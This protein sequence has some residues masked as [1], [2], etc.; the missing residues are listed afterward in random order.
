MVEACIRM[1]DPKNTRVAPVD[2]GHGRGF[3]LIELMVALA[4]S[5][6]LLIGA[7]TIYMQGRTSFRINESISR[8]QEDAR[9]ALDMLEPDI[10]M[11]SYFGLQSRPAMVE[12]RA[13]AL[14]PV[15]AGLAVNDDCRQNWAIDLDRPVEVSNNAY[16]WGGNCPAFGNG[17]A[18]GGDT[19]VVRRV[20]EDPVTVLNPNAMHLQTARFRTNVLFT[21]AAI[22]GGFP[23]GATATHDLVVNGYYVSQSSDGDLNTPSLRRYFLRAGAG[24]P[25]VEDE[26]ILPGVEDMQIQLGV[27]TDPPNSPTRGSVNRYVNGDDPIIDPLDPAFIDDAQIIAVRIWLLV[28]TDRPENG[29][30]D[31]RAYVYADRNFA[32]PNDGFRRM[33]VSRTI[34]LRNARTII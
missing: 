5:S 3:T 13:D 11:A 27:D 2:A 6:F 8:L 26:E 4:I 7:V 12:N 1:M 34:F 9:F 31:D 29:F 16:A 24:G 10:R 28:R 22:P 33:L 21:G 30:T 15:P 32:A 14:D 17:A 23:V 18:A 25:D 20:S 19:L